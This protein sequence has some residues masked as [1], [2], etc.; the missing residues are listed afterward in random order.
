MATAHI[1]A[2]LRRL[3]D[4]FLQHPIRPLTLQDAVGVAG[5]DVD[6]CGIMLAALADVRFVRPYGVAAF[7][8]TWNEGVD[9]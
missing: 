8:C 3:K 9:A 7:V 6:T 4:A 1:D 2:A 5:V